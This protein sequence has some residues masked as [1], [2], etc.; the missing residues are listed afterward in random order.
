LANLLELRGITK[1]FPGVLA[2]DHIDLVFEKGTIHALVGE[3]GAGKSTL[4]NILY[5]LYHPDEGEILLNGQ[6]VTFSN[7]TA[8]IQHGIGMVHQHF[9]LVPSFTVYENI[10]LAAEP[11]HGLLGMFFDRKKAVKDVLELAEK[12]GFKIDP[13]ARVRNL[14]VGAQQRIEIL[15]T[16]YRGADILILDEPTAVL[17]P[18]ETKELFVILRG[19]V[20]AGKTIIFITHKLEEVMEISDHVTVMRAGRVTM[21]KPISETSISEMARTM[22][23]REVFLEMKKKPVALSDVKLSVNNLWVADDRGMLAVKG[24]NFEIRGGE[25]LGVAGVAGNGQTELVEAVTG[26]RKVELGHVQIEGKETTGHSPMAI[27]E[28][29]LAHIPEDRYKRGVAGAA[30]VE[31][32]S[33]MFFHHKAPISKGVQIDYAAVAVH[34]EAM[35]EKFDVRPRQRK[36]PAGKLSGGNAQKLIAGRE[37]SLDTPVLVASQPTRGLDIGAIEFLHSQIVAARDAGH[38]VLLVSTELDEVM[39]LSDRIIV[40]N[41][42]QLIG[43]VPAKEATREGLGLLMAGVRAKPKAAGAEQ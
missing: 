28:A 37:I 41:E 23:G 33:I 8:A 36:T 34:A 6:P 10:V 29:G 1:R 9:M 35:M 14:P 17:T 31:E 7:P 4:M 43:E 21:D 39:S 16:L 2:N 27:R 20:D 12:N 32:N 18:Q 3:N 26:L 15:K 30:S 5:G 11:K 38:A 13:Q 19:L 22:V 40:L 25:I 42:G 24:L